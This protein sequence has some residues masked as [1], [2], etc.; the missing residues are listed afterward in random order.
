MKRAT[1]AFIGGGLLL[2][3]LGIATGHSDWARNQF[4]EIPDY[5]NI[6][7]QLITPEGTL[8]CCGCHGNTTDAGPEEC[9]CE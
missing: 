2:F 7:K 3:N 5:V 6:P 9:F 1:A 8:D 4:I